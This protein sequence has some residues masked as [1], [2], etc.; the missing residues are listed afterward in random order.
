MRIGMMVGSDRERTRAD[1]LPGLIHD[2]VSV[3][4]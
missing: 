3:L 1:R 4:P 2:G